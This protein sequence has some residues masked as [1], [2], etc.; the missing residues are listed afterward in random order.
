MQRFPASA[1]HCY[2]LNEAYVLT[3]IATLHCFNAFELLILCKC[4]VKA[5]YSSNI[6]VFP[7][8]ESIDQTLLFPADQQF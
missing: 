7:Y 8:D 3:K 4:S 6:E 2:Y 1:A 5:T